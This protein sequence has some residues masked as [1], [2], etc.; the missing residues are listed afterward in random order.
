MNI[1]L[2]TSHRFEV[3]I[4][5]QRLGFRSISGLKITASFE[6]LQVGGMNGSPVLLP[7][8]VKEPGRLVLERGISS[9]NALADFVPGAR[10][11][12]EM[13]IHIVNEKGR[14]SVTYSVLSP[15]VESIELSKLDALESTAIIE[16]FSLLHYGIEAL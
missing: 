1:S 5:N 8:P 14:S 10:I 7:V 16:T 3:H 2:L 12:E 6:P 9:L 13:Q 11:A 15:I 4:K